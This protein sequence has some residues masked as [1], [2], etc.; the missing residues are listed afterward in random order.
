MTS[1]TRL[2]GIDFEGILSDYNLG[3][4]EQSK[5]LTS[6]AVQTSYLLRTSRGKFVL[7]YY[8]NRPKGSVLF[9]SNLL[10]Y[11][12]GNNY[13]CPVPCNSDYGKSVGTYNEKPYIIFEFLE[14]HNIRFPN[15]R[16]KRQLIRKVAELHKI[17]RGYIPRYKKFR[18]NYSIEHCSQLARKKAYEVDTVD[19]IKKVRWLES[20]LSKLI[21][22][23]S[24]P[25]GICHCDLGFSNVL[26]KNGKF[27]ALIDFDDANYTFLAFDLA[28]WVNPFINSF[29]WSTW[30]NF[31]KETPPLEFSK[32][33]I[34]VSIY[35]KYRQLNH[36]EKLHFFDLLKLSV[37]FD[38]I[39]YFARGNAADFYEKRKIEYLN[40][41][42]RE[43]FYRNLFRRPVLFSGCGRSSAIQTRN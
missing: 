42:G 12:K 19:A 34:L 41:M 32:S 2:L 26:F 43:N 40:S 36:D 31:A 5:R 20:E 8:E 30:S 14:G 4:Y 21:L 37:L 28:N 33:R 29:T 7:K 11:L 13:P 27:K 25:K 39:W 1:K 10:K 23:R 22:P 9:E 35:T 17:T 18:L 38:C 24:L 6:G 15:E 16:Q 3:R